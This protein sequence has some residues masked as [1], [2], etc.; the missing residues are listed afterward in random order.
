MSNVVE[1][2]QPPKPKPPRKPRP[3]LRRLLIAVGVLAALA[4]AWGYF[5]IVGG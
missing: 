4:A 1:F 5:T 2:K 3:H